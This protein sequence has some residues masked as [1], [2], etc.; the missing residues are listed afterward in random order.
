[1][2]VSE[3]DEHAPGAP[4]ALARFY[5]LDL[6]DDPG[7]LDLYLALARRTAS[8][9][10]VV[11]LATGTGRIAVPLAEAG[12]RVVGV[13]LDPAMLDRA[14]LRAERSDAEG[15]GDRLRWLQADLVDV[16]RGSPG[17][18]A[19]ERL[20][21][22]GTFG[23]AILAVGSI[24]LLP[25][26]EAQRAAIATMARLLAPEGVAVVDAW[27]VPEGERRR[28]DGSV[29]LEWVRVEP[30]T[31]AT[32]TKLASGRY[33]PGE[34]R[35]SLTTLFDEARLGEP[36]VRWSRTDS[37]RLVEAVELVEFVRDAG[38]EPEAVARDPEMSPFDDDPAADADADRV[39]IVARRPRNLRREAPPG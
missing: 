14:R 35:I 33:D 15:V 21:A 28:F 3:P 38:L 7:D 6:L 37:L 26:A 9:G 18:A 10:P 24:L 27:L 8:I 1:M 30:A 17:L 19:A 32:V 39:V 31:G 25:D 34:R 5:D 2:A 36:I 22:P 12:H 20:V 11:E 13:D 4:A 29:S 16:D 23:L